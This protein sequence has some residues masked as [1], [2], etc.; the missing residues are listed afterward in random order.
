HPPGLAPSQVLL[1]RELSDPDPGRLG[2]DN[3]GALLDRAWERAAREALA[4]RLRRAVRPTHGRVPPDAEAVLFDDA[5]EAWACWARERVA[6]PSS[7]AAPW[8]T[9]SLESSSD[10]PA[11]PMGRSPSLEAVWRGRPRL[12]P[13]LAAHL[14]AWDVAVEVVGQMA[15]SEAETVLRA[16]CDAFDVPGPPTSKGPT[17]RSDDE[18]LRSRIQPLLPD[19]QSQVE[20]GAPAEARSDTASGPSDGPPWS[21][22]VED[23]GGAG[24]ADALAEQSPAY[25]QLLGVAL[26]LHERP[27]AVR[28]SDF[29]SAWQAWQTTVDR[30]STDRSSPQVRR[31]ELEAMGE[32]EGRSTGMPDGISEEPGSGALADREGSERSGRSSR[33]EHAQDEPS[34]SDP[35]AATALGG[36]L[37]LVNVLDALD[38]PAA[39]ETPP[40]GEHVGAWATLEALARTL[41]GPDDDTLRPNDPLWRVLAT[42]DGRRPEARAGRALGEKADAPDAYRIPPAWLEAPHVDGPVDGRW[43]MT[44]GRLR[45]WTD[46]GCV[47]DLA[48]TDDPAAQAEAAWEQFPNTGRLRRAESDD[49]M[50][51]APAPDACAPVLARWAARAAPY[52]RHRLATALGVEAARSDDAPVEGEAADWVAELFAVDAR[53]YTTDLNVDLVCPLDAADLDAR[54]AGLDRSPGWWAPGGR[55]VRFHFRDPEV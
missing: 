36:V 32:P 54:V 38:L 41:L 43:A 2:V 3:A 53:L 14:A 46:L 51:L 21:S 52:L 1:V 44:E 26:T 9:E 48:V 12:V 16:V 34:W 47:A 49:T 40:V 31:E 18:A 28:S 39:T 11:S 55:I 7:A 27:S 13:A 23:V 5:A 15:E 10:A 22:F 50:P 33:E 30:S 25:R 8:W 35:Y 24:L 42:L 19:D 37:Y 45:V 20:E 17:G 4:D 29:Q 6:G